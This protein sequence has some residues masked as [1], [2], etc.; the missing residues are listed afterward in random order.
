MSGIPR[1]RLR[2]KQLEHLPGGL[3][4]AGAI[5]AVG[6]P[7]TPASPSSTPLPQPHQTTWKGPPQ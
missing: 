1:T 4:R 6:R 7:D 3:S 2:M 5:Q